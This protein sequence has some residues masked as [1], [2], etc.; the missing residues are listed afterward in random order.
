MRGARA[1]R[2]GAAVLLGAVHARGRAV[3]RAHAHVCAPSGRRADPG[4]DGRRATVRWSSISCS[5]RS[6]ASRRA[7]PTGRPERA[8]PVASATPAPDRSTS[9][10][11]RR[12]VWTRKQAGVRALGTL[13][14]AGGSPRAFEA[15]AVIDD[16]A[17]YHARRHRVVVERRGGHGRG[18]RGAR[19]EPGGGRQRPAARERARGLGRGRASETARVRFARDLSEIVAEDPEAGSRC[20]SRGGDAATKREPGDR[21]QRLHRTVWHVRRHTAGWRPLGE[22]SGVMEHHRARW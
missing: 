10:R 21:A 6:W 18:R 7:A 16:T 9:R 8:R 5:R 15:L 13:A 1:G 20:G 3:A 4:A 11:P 17:G 12:E 2:T 14:L 19:V 22:R